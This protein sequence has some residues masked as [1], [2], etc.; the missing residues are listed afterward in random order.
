MPIAVNVGI[1]NNI[2]EADGLSEEICSFAMT[3]AY[4]APLLKIV[5]SSFI[6]GR[7]KHYVYNLPLVK[8]YASFDQDDLNEAAEYAEFELGNEYVEVVTIFLFTCFFAPLQPL[9]VVFAMVQLFLY[10]WVQKVVLYK[11]AKRP[12]PGNDTI[13][14][15]MY[16]LVFF[17]PLLYAVGSFLWC[18]VLRYRTEGDDESKFESVGALPNTLA[19][20]LSIITI[21]LPYKVLTRE[22]MTRLS[23]EKPFKPSRFEDDRI[24]FSSEY[25]RLNPATSDEA[26]EEYQ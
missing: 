7:L 2:Y 5:N 18:G 8:F 23:D 24:F 12:T 9:V 26:G 15:A 20:V 10:F 13:N 14:T 4:M 1:K 6:V 17:G 19:F 25:D 11:I 22:L 16:Q 21:L 3:N